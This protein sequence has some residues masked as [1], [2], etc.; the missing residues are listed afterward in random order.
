MMIG[1]FGQKL[2][3]VTGQNRGMLAEQCRNLVAFYSFPYKDAM[4][5]QLPGINVVCKAVYAHALNDFLNYVF[6][7]Q[8]RGATSAFV[9][10]W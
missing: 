4:Y 2:S 6:K 7:I 9:C 3:G 5:H 8:K 10:A 1:P